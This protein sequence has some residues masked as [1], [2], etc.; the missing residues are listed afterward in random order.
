[1]H[2]VSFYYWMM[3]THVLRAGHAEAFPKRFH[4]D[5]VRGPSKGNETLH[6]HAILPTSLLAS[7]FE[8]LRAE[9]DCFGCRFIPPGQYSIHDVSFHY[10]TMLTHVLR[11]GHAEAFP[12]ALPCFQGTKF[13]IL[14]IS[15]IY[16]IQLIK[17][18]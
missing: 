13:A 10:W 9:V 12:K 5:A 16:F 18:N 7:C 6:H 4:G 2:D 17:Q 15:K 1:I 3:L 8:V 14:I 11:A